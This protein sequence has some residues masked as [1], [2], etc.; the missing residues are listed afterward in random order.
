MSSAPVAIPTRTRHASSVSYRRC[1]Y[2][3]DDVS[4]KSIHNDY[5]DNELAVKNHLFDPN[6]SSPPNPWLKKLSERIERYDSKT[7]ST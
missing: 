2:E 3:I 4:C 5:V 6:N 1:Q 7:L